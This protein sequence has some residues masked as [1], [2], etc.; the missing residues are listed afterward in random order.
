MIRDQVILAIT[1]LFLSPPSGR[2][3]Q[4]HQQIMSKNSKLRGMI[5]SASG[6]TSNLYKQYP[7][8]PLL[9]LDFMSSCIRMDP[10]TRPTADDLLRHNYFLHDRFPQKFLPALREKVLAEYN[11][12]PLLRRYKA[13]VLMSSDR[14]EA[15]RSSHHLEQP[16]RWKI[17]LAEANV[18]RKFS[19]ETVNVS[20]ASLGRRSMEKREEAAKKSGSVVVL[21]SISKNNFNQGSLPRNFLKRIDQESE[22]IITPLWLGGGGGQKRRE[23]IKV[24]KSDDFC[25]PNV[26]G[27]EQ[28][29]ISGYFFVQSAISNVRSNLTSERHQC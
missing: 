25:L 7:R 18:K 4:R 17:H 21:E 22:T 9:A 16:P 1:L 23:S 27:G 6:D 29:F 5:R 12:N 20:E 26:P 8:W 24:I 28:I 11:A 10:Q 3:C 2:P 15:R 14:K 19:C 13:D